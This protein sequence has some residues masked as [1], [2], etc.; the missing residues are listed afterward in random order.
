[1]KIHCLKDWVTVWLSSREKEKERY[2]WKTGF[3]VLTR[4]LFFVFFF[5]YSLVFDVFFCFIYPNT[6][7]SPVISVSIYFCLFSLFTAPPLHLSSILFPASFPPAWLWW[8]KVW[9]QLLKPEGL[10]KA[11]FIAW[12][13]HYG[14]S[15]T[16]PNTPQRT[17]RYKVESHSYFNLRRGARMYIY[18]QD[19]GLPGA[20]ITRL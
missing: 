9:R 1:M 12:V 13:R 3:R 4:F 2:G 19:T 16:Y 8:Y 11:I 7:T 5:L 14:I 6:L 17:R 15:H 20:G 18:F 10:S